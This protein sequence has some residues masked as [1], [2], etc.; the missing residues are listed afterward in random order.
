MAAAIRL[1]QQHSCSL[2]QPHHCGPVAPTTLRRREQ[3]VNGSPAQLQDAGNRKAN[4]DESADEHTDRG[5]STFAGDTGFPHS[6]TEPSRR[7]SEA[8]LHLA[9]HQPLL[10]SAGSTAHWS[11]CLR[12]NKAQGRFDL[13]FFWTTTCISWKPGRSLLCVFCFGIASERL[14]SYPPLDLSTLLEA[15]GKEAGAFFIPLE[16]GTRS[17]RFVL[18]G[19]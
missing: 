9:L 12:R 10:R 15:P 5:Q 19:N 8:L 1:S 18:I 16:L 17:T 14:R 6:R 3:R 4:D 2:G 11:P 13:A 7:S